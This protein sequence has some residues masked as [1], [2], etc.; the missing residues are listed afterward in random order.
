MHFQPANNQCVHTYDVYQLAV[1]PVM[2]F[3]Y[4]THEALVHQ[5]GILSTG[6]C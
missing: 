1:L 2:G 5:F 3:R 6:P 4:V